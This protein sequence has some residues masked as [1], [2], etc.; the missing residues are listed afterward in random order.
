MNNQESTIRHDTLE[1]LEPVASNIRAHCETPTLE[2][3][4][5]TSGII[6]TPQAVCFGSRCP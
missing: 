5:D 3:L 6:G 2:H 1:H 4:G